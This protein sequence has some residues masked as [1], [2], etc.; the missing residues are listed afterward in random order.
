MKQPDQV[1]QSPSVALFVTCLV[2]V[3]RPSIGFA[4]VSLLE[5]AGCQVFVPE[6][7][8]CCGQPGYNAGDEKSAR[9]IAEQVIEALQGYDY[10]VV[11]SG[12]CAG[13]I[14]KHYPDLFADDA[15]W[16]ARAED[17][18]VR[19]WELTSFLVDVMK[20][21][22][23]GIT[24]DKVIS[25]HDSCSGLRELGIKDQ[26]RSLLAGVDGTKIEESDLAESC[27]GFG[28]LF[29]VKYPDI[30]TAMV[31]R[32]I[33][34]VS[35][36]GADVILGGDLGC[37]MNIAGRLSRQGKS[38]NVWHVAEVVAGMADQSASICGSHD[39]QTSAVSAVGKRP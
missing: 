33:A 3:M 37:L 25:Y 29:C 21:R 23:V 14:I 17:L 15:A 39:A 6:T 20:F 35:D 22:P 1:P 26:P 30:S 28:G 13:M 32:K 18:S 19:S 8:T 2:D 10:V 16:R 36:G 7:Q 5:R 34:E 27:C 4:A 9:G 38:T 12:S 24:F 11:P 31:D